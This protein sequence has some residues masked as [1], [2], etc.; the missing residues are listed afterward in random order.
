MNNTRRKKIEKLR[1]DLDAIKDNLSE[2]VDEEQEYFDNIPENFWG[3]E[4][5]EVAEEALD[6]LSCAMDSIEE[7]IDYLV[8][9]M[10]WEEQR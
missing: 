6:S 3:S 1:L 10:G 9:A 8:E 2:A 5:Y 4:R 7:A